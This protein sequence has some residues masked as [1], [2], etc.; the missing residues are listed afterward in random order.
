[1]TKIDVICCNCKGQLTIENPVNNP[2]GLWIC[3]QCSAVMKAFD[4]IPLLKDLWECG[5]LGLAL[6]QVAGSIDI[7]SIDPVL[8]LMQEI[9]HKAGRDLDY[10]AATTTHY[11]IDG[12]IHSIMD[13]NENE[14]W[15]R[16]TQS[17]MLCPNCNRAHSGDFD[18]TNIE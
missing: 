8:T 15:M 12:S 11:E 2:T 3:D 17:L 7:R 6:T 10:L 5:V 14:L 4:S 1:M 18:C 9:I 16:S 13:A